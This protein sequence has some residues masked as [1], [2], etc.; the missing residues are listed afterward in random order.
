MTAEPTK[1]HRW[2]LRMVGEWSFEG[3]CMM[4]PDQPPMKGSGSES[5]SQLGDLWIVSSGTIGMPD[6][7]PHRMQLTL[8]FDPQ[9]DLFV[10]TWVG[11]MMSHLWVYEGKLDAARKVLTLDCEGPDMSGAGGTAKYQDIYELVDNDHRILRSRMQGPDGAWMQ[12][13]EAHYRRV[14]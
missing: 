10:G 1:E 3:E 14:K 11:S 13:M 4:G 8:G 5:V 6:G 2:L 9:K 12:F 7:S